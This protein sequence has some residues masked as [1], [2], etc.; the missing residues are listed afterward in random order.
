MHGSGDNRNDQCLSELAACISAESPILM[1]GSG[2]SKL[3]GY[4][5]WPELMDQLQAAV[6]S[7]PTDE[8]R[9]LLQGEKYDLYADRIYERA[10]KKTVGDWVPFLEKCFSPQKTSI[11]YAENIHLP[12]L[13]MPFSG[14]VTTNYDHV[15]EE[16]SQACLA[17]RNKGRLYGGATDLCPT[18]CHP[19]DLCNDSHKRKVFELLRQLSRKDVLPH[20][21]GVLHIHGYYSNAAKIILRRS[22]YERAYG[23]LLDDEKAASRDVTL[24]HKILWAL[25]ATRPF[26]F[27]GFGMKDPF[28][29]AMQGI[30]KK[31][32]E[33]GSAE[34]LVLHYAVVPEKGAT[35]DLCDELNQ[36]GIR[37]V[38][39]PVEMLGDTNRVDECYKRGLASFVSR[40]A[41]RVA[42]YRHESPAAAKVVEGVQ[43]L[44][45]LTVTQNEISAAEATE[46][47]L[48]KLL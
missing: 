37:L 13:R 27:V 46:R 18:T 44:S 24:H 3:V 33:M 11:P 42:T 21:E 40:L 41:D 39:Y 10:D 30:V 31:Q 45:A 17:E 29:M 2:L 25:M 14:V 5:L 19:L 48:R 12:L 35:P 28:F 38:P 23:R 20:R 16:A 43:G 22:D 26:V 32:F 9:E 4:P 1:V 34:I 36:S 15:L 7:S 8:D 6:R 47:M